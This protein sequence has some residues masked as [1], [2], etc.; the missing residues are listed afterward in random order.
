MLAADRV[1]VNPEVWTEA[2][3]RLLKR[4]A[5]YKQV[6]RVLVHPAIKKALCEATAKD[7]GP[8]LAEQ[9]PAVSGGTTTTSISASPAPRAAPTARPSRRSGSDDGCGAE[10]QTL[11]SAGEEPA[12]ARTAGAGEALRSRSTSCPPNAAR[13]WQVARPRRASSAQAAPKQAP[14][15]ANPRPPRRRRRSSSGHAPAAMPGRDSGCCR[16]LMDAPARTGEGQ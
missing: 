8:R 16:G 10:L 4:A 12:Q 9:G 7:E 3:V 15:Q 5:S 14:K 6:E 13:C 11:A 2:H 1:S